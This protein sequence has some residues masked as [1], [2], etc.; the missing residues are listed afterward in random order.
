M[1]GTA[2]ELVV[3]RRRLE[4]HPVLQGRQI[5]QVQTL[6]ARGL[7]R[8][9][10]PRAIAVIVSREGARTLLYLQDGAVRPGAAMSTATAFDWAVPVRW[11]CLRCAS[12]FVTREHVPTCPRCG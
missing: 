5:R 3:L 9:A 1:V 4:T 6:R 7:A 11:L 2:Q 10:S 8:G 12:W